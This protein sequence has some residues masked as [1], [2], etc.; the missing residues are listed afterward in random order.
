MQTNQI[1]GQIIAGLDPVA[2]AIPPKPQDSSGKSFAYHVEKM[3]MDEASESS[4]PSGDSDLAVAPEDA[5]GIVTDQIPDPAIQGVTSRPDIDQDAMPVDP[6]DL[7]GDGRDA[8]FLQ[9]KPQ[10]TGGVDLRLN[11]GQARGISGGLQDEVG[12]SFN[13]GQPAG[14]PELAVE[15]G[16]GAAQ[17]PETPTGNQTPPPENILPSNVAGVPTLEMAARNMHQS[18]Q[19]SFGQAYPVPQTNDLGQP[20]GN[21]AQQAS[22]GGDPYLSKVSVESIPPRTAPEL[23]NL[24]PGRYTGAV[25]G[26]EIPAGQT[27][28]KELSFDKI[29]TPVGEQ[30]SKLA[31]DRVEIRVQV[32][33]QKSDLGTTESKPPPKPGFFPIPD[34]LAAANIRGPASLGAVD[35]AP[36][37]P[38]QIAK[39]T[40]EIYSKSSMATEAPKVNFATLSQTYTGTLADPEVFTAISDP[41]TSTASATVSGIPVAVSSGIPVQAG[42]MFNGAVVLPGVFAVPDAPLEDGTG[43]ELSAPSTELALLPGSARPGDS[44]VFPPGTARAVAVQLAEALITTQG[45]KVDIVL[46]PVELG[47]VRMVLSP[48]ESG[49]SVSI[50]A[51]RP[52]TLELMRRHIDQLTEEFRALGY[53]D[54]GFEFSGEGPDR[55]FDDGPNDQQTSI[56]SESESRLLAGQHGPESNPN[57]HPRVSRGL[58]MRL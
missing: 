28:G 34:G 23:M 10:E 54:I 53:Q 11:M 52:E 32:D 47:R 25:S 36:A 31:A 3:N 40:P 13:T 19:P 33:P 46:N 49:I 29:R 14:R 51:E 22:G 20:I 2:M 26:E 43:A 37:V 57:T 56:E 4:E 8:L 45:S 21:R 9:E 42:A 27:T 35:S 18:V 1:P 16:P 6:D 5:E 12:A 41:R 7:T 58:D 50:T 30:T 38:A 24:T 17:Y 39:T 55:D 44:T 15:L 48:S